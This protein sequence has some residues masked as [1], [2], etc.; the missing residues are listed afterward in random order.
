MAYN[1]DRIRKT[2]SVNISDV[3]NIDCY[4]RLCHQRF[5]CEDVGP[6]TLI[7]GKDLMKSVSLQYTQLLPCL[8]IE[9]WP[10][11]LDARRMQLCPFK[12]GK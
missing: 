10:A 7:Q 4:V 9:V 3:Q 5:V 11:I 8:C 1:V 12:N 6:V 2:I